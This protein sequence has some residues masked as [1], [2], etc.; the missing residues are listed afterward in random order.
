MAWCIWCVPQGKGGEFLRV[1][2]AILDHQIWQHNHE[3]GNDET[4]RRKPLARQTDHKHF[5]SQLAKPFGNAPSSLPRSMNG[6]PLYI[7][8]WLAVNLHD[9][10]VYN[11]VFFW[12]HEE[13]QWKV[14]S[15]LQPLAV[16]PKSKI[17]LEYPSLPSCDS[18]SQPSVNGVNILGPDDF[19]LNIL[20]PED[21]DD[22]P[23][24]S[25]N[26]LHC[27]EAED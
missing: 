2:H 10:T 11:F 21:C 14:G 26:L 16:N 1:C 4:R 15:E 18:Q 23:H 19:D 6:K 22:S 20:K 25:S 13:E 5:G 27:L 17:G 7:G 3:R 8:N 9:L 24:F 12:P